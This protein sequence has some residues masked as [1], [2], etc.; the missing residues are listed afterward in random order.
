[1]TD[2]NISGQKVTISTDINISAPLLEISDSLFLVSYVQVS[3]L[4]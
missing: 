4:I 3:H 1:M 2:A